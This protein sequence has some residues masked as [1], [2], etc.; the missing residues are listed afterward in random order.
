MAEGSLAKDLLDSFYKLDDSKVLSQK[1][2]ENIFL[3]IEASQYRNECQFA[4]S[5]RN[6]IDI[7]S[8]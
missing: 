7:D 5:Y 1:L 8:I 6:A 2:R 4:F 3:A